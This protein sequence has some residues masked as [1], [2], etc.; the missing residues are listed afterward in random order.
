MSKSTGVNRTDIITI[1]ANKTDIKKADVDRVLT[2]FFDTIVRELEKD[3]YVKLTGFGVFEN[4]I[5]K[6]RE[7]SSPLTKETVQ[8]DY[9]VIPR[10]RPSKAVK[11]RINKKQAKN[12]PE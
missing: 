2:C 4:S 9:R 1:V 3:H 8:L 6:G 5:F 10:F 11:E 7:L 12:R